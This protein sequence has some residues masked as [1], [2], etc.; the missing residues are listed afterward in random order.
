MGAY[1]V[2]QKHYRQRDL[3]AREW[4]KKGGK[5]VGYFCDSVPEEMILAAGFFPLRL[6][7]DP[8]GS[9][10]EIDKYL[11]SF[12]EGFVR[13]E[14]NMILTGQYDFVDFIVIPRSRDSITIQYSHLH[15]IKALDPAIKMPKLYLFEFNHTRTYASQF[16]DL[17]RVRDFKKQLEEWSGKKITNKALSRAIAITNENKMLLKQVAALRAGEPPRISGVEALQI[18]GSSMFMLKEEHNKLLKQ[19]LEGASKL[20]ARDGVRLFVEGSP[21]DNLQLYEII[22]SCKATIVAEDHCWGNR[23]SDSPIDTSRDPV[24]AIADRYHFKS[25]CPFVVFPAGLRAEYCVRNAVEAK[26]QGV[27]F[28]VLEWDG[29][30]TWDYP[31]QKEVLEEKGIPTVCFMEQKYLLSEPDRIKTSTEKLIKAI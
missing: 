28:Y 23:Y 16:Y 10:E 14:L 20:P 18:I 15:Q 21:L 31:G 1:E 12:Y 9:T 13:S 24:E 6:T 27:I 22:E 8:R 5:V 3:S 26:A 25:P 11:E 7:G 17:G 4:K 29:D 19:F 30:G 2:M